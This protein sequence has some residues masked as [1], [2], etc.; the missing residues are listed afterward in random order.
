[1]IS[2]TLSVSV[3]MYGLDLT[4]TKQKAFTDLVHV[5]HRSTVQYST[6]ATD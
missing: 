3:S 1:M 6:W 2:N 4:V 5:G